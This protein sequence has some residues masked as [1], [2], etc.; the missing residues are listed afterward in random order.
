MLSSCTCQIRLSVSKAP[1]TRRS[2]TKLLKRDTTNATRACL[3]STLP[4]ILF[5]KL[6]FHQP[7]T[8]KAD[9]TIM[10]RNDSLINQLNLL[11]F[12]KKERNHTFAF[13]GTLLS[14]QQYLFLTDVSRQNVLNQDDAP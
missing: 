4:S 5:I 2:T 7:P 9:H 6:D 14:Q 12:F 3:A 8:R 13:A 11:F 1:S 10:Q